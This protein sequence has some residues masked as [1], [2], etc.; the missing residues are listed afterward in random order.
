MN[1]KLTHGFYADGTPFS[2]KNYLH[3]Y[4]KEVLLN[5]FKNDGTDKNN[6]GYT[7]SFKNMEEFRPNREVGVWKDYPIVI[8]DKFNS[9][10][11]NWDEDILNLDNI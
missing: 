11:S 9:V 4:S 8:D 1:I 10:E 6:W 7:Q 5:W 3:Q 2:P